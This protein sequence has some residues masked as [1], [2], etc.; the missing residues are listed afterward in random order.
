MVLL[1]RC[2]GNMGLNRIVIIINA[3]PTGF[4]SFFVCPIKV[5][6]APMVMAILRKV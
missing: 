3:I 4:T 6:R 5:S 1:F 2:T